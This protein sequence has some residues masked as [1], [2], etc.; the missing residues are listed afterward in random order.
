MSFE[1]VVELLKA[2]YEKAKT[3]K[4]V[5]KPLA[6]AIYKTWKVVAKKRENE[7]DTD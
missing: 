5:R 7:N 1:E 6:Y 3:L 4:F 2:E